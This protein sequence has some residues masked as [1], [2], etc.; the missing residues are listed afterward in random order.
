MAEIDAQIRGINRSLKI[1]CDA[2]RALWEEYVKLQEK[3]RR[4][5]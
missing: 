3:Y 2:R 4:H 5:P 1:L